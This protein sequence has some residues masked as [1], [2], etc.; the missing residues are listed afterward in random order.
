MFVELLPLVPVLLDTN[1]FLCVFREELNKLSLLKISDS[2]LI[3]LFI[4][5]ILGLQEFGLFILI[6]SLNFKL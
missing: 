1:L 4:T 5:I 6:F 2:S 3:S